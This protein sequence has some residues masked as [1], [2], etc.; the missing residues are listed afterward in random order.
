MF[1]I[2][3]LHKWFGLVLGLQLLIWALSGA[4]MALIDHHQVSG[5][6]ALLPV[7][8]LT[9]GPAPA[10]LA[11]VQ[12]AVGAPI[13]KLELK[14]LFDRWVYKASTADGVRLIDAETARPFEVDAALARTLA[15]GRYAGAAPVARVDLV[16]A[17]TYETRKMAR[18]VWRVAYADDAHTALFV[19]RA[20]GE[21]LGAKTDASRLWDIAW[22]FH[23]MDY[24]ARESFNHPL[25]VTVASGVTWLALSGLILLFRS[26]RSSD[27]AWLTGPFDRWSGRRARREP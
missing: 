12:A 20:T 19:S 8:Q 6:H 13:V 21:V 9:S 4:V 18:P 22:M 25:I 27:V 7:A 5:E 17:V 11:T 10:P 2:R 23:I 14:P 24:T 26:F 15:T 3:T 16:E 1:L